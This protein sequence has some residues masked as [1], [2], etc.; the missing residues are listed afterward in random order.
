MFLA[1]TAISG[2]VGKGTKHFYP[3]IKFFTLFSYIYINPHQ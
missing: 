1:A 3:I 2:K